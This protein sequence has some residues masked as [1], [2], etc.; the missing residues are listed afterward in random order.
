[1]PG[2]GGPGWP[3]TP[4][5]LRR[6]ELAVTRRVHGLREGDHL[7]LLTGHGVEA[8]E[9]RLY[10]PG[11]DVRRIDWTVTARTAVPHVR[12][13][14]AE[15]ELDVLALVDLSGSL[16]FGTAGRRKRDLGLTVLAGLGAL[17][18]RG[19]DRFGA[20][21]LTGEG[22]RSVPARAGRTQLASLLTR[23]EA[24]PAEGASDLREGLERLELVARRRGLVI[25]ISDFLGPFTWERAMA[26]L[27]RRH[28]TLAIELVDPR[29][30]RFPDVGF[31]TLVDAE[32]GRRRTVDTGRPEIRAA[33]A[34]QARRRAA[35]VAEALR[36]A[37]ATHL[38]LMTDQDWVGPLVRILDQQ[39]RARA[40]GHHPGQAAPGAIR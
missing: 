17:A 35:A 6:A 1:M 31:L 40:V 38:R 19:H 24:I 22:I 36:R 7:A 14:I 23:A 21:L 37:G 12:D 39:R 15:R 9:A 25:V 26:R 16:D 13:A 29:E 30:V 10:A 34:A 3:A 11:D 18:C 5:L 33:Y 32:S 28:D 2:G 8:A 4:D 27:A 20:V